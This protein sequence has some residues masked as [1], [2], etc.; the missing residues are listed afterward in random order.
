MVGNDDNHTVAQSG[1]SVKIYQGIIAVLV[2]TIA[3][4]M[5]FLRHT[6][7]N[8]ETPIGED[9]PLFE[10]LVTI[11]MGIGFVAGIRK[12]AIVLTTEWR[13]M[14][15]TRRRTGADF[16]MNEYI[17]YRIDNLFSSSK[18][19]KIYFLVGATV[20]LICTGGVVWLLV[21]GQS[22]SESLWTAWT[23]VADPGTHA[24][25]SGWL[26]RAVSFVLTVGG[27]VIFA[28]VIGII[29]EEIGCF[30]DNLRKGKSR[31]VETGHTLIIGQVYIVY[32]F[33]DSRLRAEKIV[34][35]CVLLLLLLLLL[36]QIG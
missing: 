7:Q 2:C 26:L 10:L 18:K 27:M 4:M 25:R 30:V 29:S 24:E 31:V 23:F 13:L 20:A 36:L 6:P 14:G 33:N 1:E 15:D 5:P 12:G 8:E 22:F 21:S 32:L 9:S 16:S 3:C 19:Y 17:G 28:M 34:F 35:C 11:V